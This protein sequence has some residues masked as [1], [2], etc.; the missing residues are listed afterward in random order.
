ME[1]A[2][3]DPVDT[4]AE[5]EKIKADPVIGLTSD[6]DIIQGWYDEARQCVTPDALQKLSERLLGDVQYSVDVTPH[7]Y[8]AIALAGL[9]LANSSRHGRLS[10]EQWETV[11]G[12]LNSAL[13]QTLEADAESQAQG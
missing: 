10:A 1:E 4:R 5:T 3:K 2:K 13:D 12:M 9:K 11:R 6:T 7:A 8:T